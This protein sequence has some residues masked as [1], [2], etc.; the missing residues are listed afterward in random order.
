MPAE[1]SRTGQQAAWKGGKS[2][3]LGIDRVGGGLYTHM[4]YLPRQRTPA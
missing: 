2:L 3:V 4:L 1:L